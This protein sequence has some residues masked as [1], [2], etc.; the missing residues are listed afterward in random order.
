MILDAGGYR[1]GTQKRQGGNRLDLGD[2]SHWEVCGFPSGGKLGQG[3]EVGGFGKV[4]DDCEDDGRGEMWDLGMC[5]GW[6]T[7]E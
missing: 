3:N 1:W 2:V 6:R 4:V 7:L 5:R